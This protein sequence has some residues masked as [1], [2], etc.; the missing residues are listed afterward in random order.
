[1]AEFS[2]FGSNVAYQ[3]FAK[4]NY[5]DKVKDDVMGRACNT[6]GGEEECIYDFDGKARRQE[7]IRKT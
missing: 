3:L 7:T 2:Y 1:L 6:N 4:C 5:N